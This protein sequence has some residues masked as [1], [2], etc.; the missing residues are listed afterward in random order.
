MKITE[1]N[2][3]NPKCSD[4]GITDAKYEITYVGE[5]YY[6]C[7]DSLKQAVRRHLSNKGIKKE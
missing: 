2:P 4:C 6:L 7:K 1:I 3:S 5:T